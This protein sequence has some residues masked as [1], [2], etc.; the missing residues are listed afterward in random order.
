ML[1][2]HIVLITGMYGTLAIYGDY[3]WFLYEAT[4]T[5]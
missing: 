4:T 2:T 1:R 3:S 5:L